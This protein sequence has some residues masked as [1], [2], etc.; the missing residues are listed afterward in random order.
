MTKT[1]VKPVA[2]GGEL[3]SMKKFGKKNQSHGLLVISSM[4]MAL[5]LT[6]HSNV[7]AVSQSSERIPNQGTISYDWRIPLLG[8]WGGVRLYETTYGDLGNPGSIVFSGERAS[9]AEM[10]MRL[11]KERGYNTVR[12]LWE[13]PTSEQGPEWGYNKGWMQRFIDIAETLDMWMIVDCHGYTD[14][15]YY[16]EEWISFWENI[17]SDFR[18][19]YEKIVWEPI[20]EPVMGNLHGQA[21]VDK[22]K[23]IYQGW[24]DMCRSLGDT[25]WIVISG[26]CWWN[27]LPFVDWFPNMNDSLNMIFLNYHFYYFYE[28]HQDAWTEE[29]AETHADNVYN[30][31]QEVIE[32]HNRSFLCT[33]LGAD[34][35]VVLPPDVIFPGSAQYTP[36]TLAFVQRLI[37]RFDAYRNRIG[38]ILWPGGDW[39]NAELY[40]AMNIW[41]NLLTY[42]A[43]P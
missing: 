21:A 25:H 20:N 13:P 41:G 9:N 7:S 12:A 43:F 18:Y 33:E 42:E 15:Y 14:P 11:M 19:S 40:G 4:I 38:Y 32:T 23:I 10:V 6:S 39:S 2:R 1:K 30:A 17:I 5:F 16:E 36:V 3:N 28:Y 22:L 35:G 37:S 34:C 27:S 29:E 24:V 26:V 31:I 8:G